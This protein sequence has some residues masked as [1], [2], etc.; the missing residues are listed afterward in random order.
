MSIKVLVISD[1]TN[2]ISSRPEAEV[3]L[4][5]HKMGVEIEVM[6]EAQSEYVQK[7]KDAGITI[8]PYT[9]KR[10]ND[11]K[12]IQL[13][14]STLKNGKHHVLHLFNTNAITNGI[15]AAKNL[16]VK[17]IAYRGYSSGIYWYDIGAYRHI[18]HSRI[19]KIICN[20]SGVAELIQRQSFFNKNKTVT[21]NKGHRIAWYDAVEPKDLSE[22]N[23]GKDT[24]TV[25]CVANNRTMK[26]I[27]YLMEA[28]NLLPT[29]ADIQLLL[30]GNDLDN[31]ESLKILSK[32]KNRSKVQFLGYR[33]DALEIVKAADVFVLASI[34]GESIT[35]A[36]IEAMGCG[37]APVITNI[38]GNREL[39]V[40]EESGL[41]VPSKNPKAIGDAL[42]RL[43]QNRDKIS[44]FALKARER[45]ATRFSTEY[46]AQKTFELY[47]EV[48][49][50]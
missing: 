45:I 8:I 17:V 1:Y 7:F 15:K 9:P 23:I 40:H 38:P 19:D 41:V 18:L 34:T 6:T 35:K 42:V 32:G 39:V 28:V 21:I 37:T 47:Q 25:V 49:N 48:T 14:R 24:L 29:D 43:H 10:K 44:S 30:I 22:F 50:G 26:G 2:D 5:L 20:S 11:P 12:A 3:F 33:N 27:K 16:N 36:V 31:P 46:T 13:I 4:E